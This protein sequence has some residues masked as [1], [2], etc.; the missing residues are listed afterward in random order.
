MG[1]DEAIKKYPDYS[2]AYFWR[3]KAK[4]E[5]GK[6]EMALDQYQAAI[7][8][9]D[10]AI[11]LY[12]D[13]SEAYISR[14]HA[15][16]EL[17][18]YQA[19]I[20]DYNKVTDELNLDF[21]D[22]YDAR[23]AA[24]LELARSKSDSKN[25]EEARILYQETI[26]D[27]T[28]VIKYINR[29]PKN[30]KVNAM[31]YVNRGYAKLNIDDYVGAIQDYTEATELNPKYAVAYL[32]RGLAKAKGPVPDYAAAIEDYTY[33]INL[34]PGN[35]M[36][37]RAYLWLG[38]AK[39]AL[40]KGESAKLDHAKAYYYVGKANS[41]SGHYKEAIKDFN[42]SIDLNP[43]DAK[44]YYELGNTKQKRGDYEEAKQH[45]QEVTN[46]KPD[47]AEAYYSLGVVYSHLNN[48]KVALEHFNKA[49]RKKPKF[50]EAAEAHYNLGVMAYRLGNYEIARDHF[51]EA[52]DLNE[53]YAKAWK[54]SAE[55]NDK[56]GKDNA[57]KINSAV[58]HWNM[59]A[60]SYERAEYQEA[61]KNF[62]TA[63]LEL[64]AVNPDEID[65]DEIGL[66]FPQDRTEGNLNKSKLDLE[67]LA[68]NLKRFIG[69]LLAKTYNYQARA[70][71]KLGKSKADLGD[72]EGAQNLYQE[73]IRY[74]DKAIDLEPENA[75][76]WTDSGET[77]LL[78][79]VTHDYS[80]MVEDYHAAIKDCTKAINRE[81]NSADAYNL[82]GRARC[83]LG[84]AKSTQEDSKEARELYNLAREDFKQAIAAD[85]NNASYHQNLGLVNAALGKA[86]A[87]LSAFEKA[88]Q[89]EAASKKQVN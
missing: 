66:I 89:L 10:E 85:P 77:K 32:Y 30:A 35:A 88:K 79:A 69:Y 4:M 40:G 61:V 23:G 45:Y 1:F 44:A 2:K 7:S 16:M 37:G 12:P 68:E 51:H 8:D 83:L 39:E 46:R 34:N 74:L 31:V 62:K 26:A 54:G 15:K 84:Y 58:A 70:K 63:A 57:A 80:E 47:Y 82:R 64:E 36:L 56:L 86:K 3:G 21:A 38:N 67:N 17:G 18:Q 87:A 48:Y 75:L 25:L 76:Y 42:K 22:A 72:L 49:I 60:E 53:S 41:N 19:A 14:G 29:V 43:D 71:G 13:S 65:P 6:A 55:V 9:F 59:G 50:A 78:R 33:A 27:Y 5:R 20:K 28:K 24:K 52:I 81:S 73:A 11:D